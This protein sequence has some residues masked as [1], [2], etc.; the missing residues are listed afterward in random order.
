MNNLSWMLYLADVLPS[1]STLLISVGFIV[2]WKE[3]RAIELYLEGYG[4]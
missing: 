1:L 3:V 2:L 4:K